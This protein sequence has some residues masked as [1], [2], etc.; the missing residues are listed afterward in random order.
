MDFL[1]GEIFG[2]LAWAFPGFIIYLLLDLYMH[3]LNPISFVLTLFIIGIVLISTSSIAFWISGLTKTSRNVWG[4]TS[5]L[6]IFMTI[7]PP[8]FYSYTLLPKPKHSWKT[9]S[10]ELRPM[11]T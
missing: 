2:A 4:L 7:I 11:M 8:T 1:L 3:L 10:G 5:L 6:S 9:G